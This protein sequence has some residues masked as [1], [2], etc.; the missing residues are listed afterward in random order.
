MPKPDQDYYG[1]K[2]NEVTYQQLSTLIVGFK[3]SCLD[4]DKDYN[5][6]SVSGSYNTSSV[7]INIERCVQYPGLAFTCKSDTEI[8]D[9]LKQYNF[10]FYSLEQ[11][12]D[13]DQ[14]NGKPVFNFAS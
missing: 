9:F 3:A 7:M 5:L 11:K 10:V 2:M 1:Q 13:A 4:I 6:M 8:N 12:L 14:F